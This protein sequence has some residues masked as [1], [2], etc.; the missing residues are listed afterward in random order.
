MQDKHSSEVRY[1]HPIE[2]TIRTEIMQSLRDIE[3]KH[4]VTILFAC[5]SGSRAWGFASQDSDYDV[6]FIYVNWLPWY[7]GVEPRRDVIELPISNA[8]DINGWELRKTLG[9]LLR[10]NPVLLEWLNSPVVYCEAQEAVQRLHA[11]ARQFFSPIKAHHHYLSMAQKSFRGHLQ[12]DTVRLKKYLYALRP[13]LAVRWINAGLGQPPTRFADLVKK[14]VD[15]P[16][17]IRE[18]DR[19]LHVKMDADEAKSGA[20][21]PLL[22]AF[23]EKELEAGKQSRQFDY[24]HNDAKELDRFLL[25]TVLSFTDKTILK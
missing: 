17:L 22:H 16:E 3:T 23:I 14:T 5:E 2:E 24:P 7:L 25:N 4:D 19:L 11:L 8:L 10:S 12:G 18:I 20:R 21:W 15:D 6:R 9:L 13:L 1:A